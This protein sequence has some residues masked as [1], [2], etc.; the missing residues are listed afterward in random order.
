[1]ADVALLVIH[2]L[3]DDPP[4][5]ETRWL[6]TD[7]GDLLWNSEGDGKWHRRVDTYGDPWEAYPTWWSE[8]PTVP[9][10]P[11]ERLT[12]ADLRHL[13]LAGQPG[14]YIDRAAAARLRA[15][16]PGEEGTK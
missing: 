8:L 7:D 4:T 13:T 2:H 3:P 14:A 10:D 12:L 5:G 15:N 9:A 6:Y 16:L 1:V 11:S